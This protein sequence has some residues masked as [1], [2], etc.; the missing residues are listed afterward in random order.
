MTWAAALPDLSVLSVDAVPEH[1]TQVKG[2]MNTHTHRRL[3]KGKMQRSH[4]AACAKYDYFP[5]NFLYMSVK[6][7]YCTQHLVMFQ[8]SAFLLHKRSAYR[9]QYSWECGQ[10]WSTWS[11]P[12]EAVILQTC[13]FFL[14]FHPSDGGS[15][16]AADGSAGEL[17]LIPLA[18]HILAALND[19]TRRGD[20]YTAME[21]VRKRLWHSSKLN[22]PSTIS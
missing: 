5:F 22:T 4:P 18:D 13:Q 3:R 19:W 2:Q 16:L 11:K 17:R 20:W 14:P 8:R 21:T 1:E 10:A 15:W 7:L 12:R 9:G 6:T